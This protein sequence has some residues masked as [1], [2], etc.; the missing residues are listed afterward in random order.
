MQLMRKRMKVRRHFLGSLQYFQDPGS[1]LGLRFRQ[2]FPQLS[3]AN[4]EKR[5]A[6]AE[7]I[8]QF[9]GDACAFLLL[10]VDQAPAQ[11]VEGF[12]RCLTL[13]DINGGTNVAAESAVD[14]KPRRSIINYPAK[15]TVETP[16]PVFHF[17]R[18]S[19]VKRRRV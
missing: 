9:P 15:L 8:V 19:R 7:V 13:R 12:F 6:L 14:F 17:E 3:E 16:Q 2:L 4:T 5:Q 11:G 10:S 18:S 1:L